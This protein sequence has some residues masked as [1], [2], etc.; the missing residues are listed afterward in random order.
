MY[1]VIESPSR[2]ELK[3]VR[4]TADL[5]TIYDS[6]RKRLKG[7]DLVLAYL[8]DDKVSPVFMN[9]LMMAVGLGKKVAVVGS[10]S[11]RKKLEP[12]LAEAVSRTFDSPEELIKRGISPEVGKQLR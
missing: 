12:L 7:A 6:V 2:G 9:E 11:I 8:P 1:T 5:E 10:R 4:D 3:K